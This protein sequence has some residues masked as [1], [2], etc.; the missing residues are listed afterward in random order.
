MI[1]LQ[2]KTFLDCVDKLSFTTVNFIRPEN[3]LA[4]LQLFMLLGLWAHALNSEHA[5]SALCL[6]A[7][8]HWLDWS[9]CHK[10]TKQDAEELRVD[11]NSL[12]SKAEVPKAN[13]TKE[14]IK[15]LN[16]LK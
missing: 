13:L 4:L 10:L 1:F 12:L 16:N 14:E 3:N 11:T 9:V 2:N 8:A 6:F 7:G 15:G 5:Q